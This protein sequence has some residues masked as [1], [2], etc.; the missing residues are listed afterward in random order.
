MKESFFAHLWI[1]NVP[2]IGNPST[3]IHVY[4]RMKLARITMP[5]CN[6]MSKC[7]TTVYNYQLNCN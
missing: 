6:L 7:C 5:H 1:E 3:Y 2:E 4:T